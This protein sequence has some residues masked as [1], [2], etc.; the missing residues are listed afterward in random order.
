MNSFWFK[1]MYSNQNSTEQI[2]AESAY[3]IASLIL[4]GTEALPIRLKI[5]LDKVLSKLPT[6][7]I[8]LVL[9]H[10][11]WT[12]EELQSGYKNVFVSRVFALFCPSLTPQ[13]HS[14][15]L[16]LNVKFCYSKAFQIL[17]FGI[18]VGI[19]LKTI[20]IECSP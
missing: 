10:F 13:Y 14:P 20:R 11:G 6:N 17:C 7:E 3:E 9:H 5:L 15:S 16:Q 2:Q 1:H 4:Y 19:D 18:C 8:N 12:I